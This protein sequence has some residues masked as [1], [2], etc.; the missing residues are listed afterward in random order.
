MKRLDLH[1]SSLRLRFGLLSGLLLL[2]VWVVMLLISF[3]VHRRNL[4]TF[5]DTQQLLYA[6]TLLSMHG[7]AHPVEPL[8]PSPDGT[9]PS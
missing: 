7:I 8:S 1:N 3:S 5:F 4:D 6:R 9:S 2:L